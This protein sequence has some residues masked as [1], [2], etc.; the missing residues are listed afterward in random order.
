M[1]R[2]IIL[3]LIALSTRTTAQDY[4]NP[5]LS[6][7]R[8]TADLLK[9]MTLDE[10][11]AQLQSFHM[12]KPKLT[13]EVLKNP[14]K[15][16]SIFHNGVGMMN[17]DFDATP[18]QTVSRRNALQRYLKTKTRLGIPTLFIDEAHHGLLAP[19]AD[20]FST[21]IAI[22]CSWDTLLIKRV[23]NYISAEASAKGTHWVHRWWMCAV[24]RDGVERVRR[25]E[26]ILF[27]AGYSELL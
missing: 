6:A 24:T 16:D 1:V 12:S 8:R 7:E 18:E 27:Y 2:I 26:N 13:N 22:A 25:M 11:I 4:R 19:N 21:S 5:Q 10:K 23:Y 17:P 15:M 20:V 14:I 3:F 9:R